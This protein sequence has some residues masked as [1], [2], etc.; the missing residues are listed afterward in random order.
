MRLCTTTAKAPPNRETNGSLVFVDARNAAAFEEGHIPGAYNIDNYNV[1]KHLPGVRPL[2]DFADTIVVYC[3]GGECEDSIF[4]ASELE[5]RGLRR[6][7]IRLFEAGMTAWSES[8]M[9]IEQGH[10]PFNGDEVGFTDASTT[11]EGVSTP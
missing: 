11:D 2:L 3:G 5:A 10:D 6:E 9:P 7:T 4:L 1:D 8:G